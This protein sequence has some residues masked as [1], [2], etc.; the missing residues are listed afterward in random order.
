MHN[1]LIGCNVLLVICC[2]STLSLCL[3]LALVVL[4]VFS[5]VLFVVPLFDDV[6]IGPTTDD[7]S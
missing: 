6:V 7:D 2:F 1:A 3:L 5:K 4:L